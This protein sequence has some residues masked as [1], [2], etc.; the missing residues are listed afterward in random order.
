MSG[1]ADWATIYDKMEPVCT[2]AT[3]APYSSFA[4]QRLLAACYR[5]PSSYN[6]CD[7]RAQLLASRA[8]RPPPLLPSLAHFCHRF[9]PRVSCY[10]WIL[11]RILKAP[12]D[13]FSTF[14]TTTAP[15]VHVLRAGAVHLQLTF[16]LMNLRFGLASLDGWHAD[17]RIELAHRRAT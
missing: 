13:Q 2:I 12:V 14:C 3:D 15:A 6:C 9:C 8:Q 7:A 4:R 17:S 1:R 5:F 10:L 11:S 16:L